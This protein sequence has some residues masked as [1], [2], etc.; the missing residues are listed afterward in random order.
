MTCAYQEIRLTKQTLQ[1]SGDESSV[2][3]ER[4]EARRWSIETGLKP[5]DVYWN[6]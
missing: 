1:R 6:G 4:K 2:F 5:H 3:L